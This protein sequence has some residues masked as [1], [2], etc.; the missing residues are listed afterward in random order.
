MVGLMKQTDTDQYYETIQ[1]NERILAGNTYLWGR[2]DCKQRDRVHATGRGD[3][4][5][6]AFGPGSRKQ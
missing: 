6:D 1:L 3:V 4:E 5:D 2:I